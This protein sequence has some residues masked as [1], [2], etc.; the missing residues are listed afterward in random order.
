[1][2][3]VQLVSNSAT[4]QQIQDLIGRS[5]ASEMDEP[6][7]VLNYT[8]VRIKVRSRQLQEIAKMSG[9]VWM[10]PWSEPVL[11]DE[12]QGLILAGKL[13]GTESPSSYL[14]WLQSKG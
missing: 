12:K 7:T 1:M 10:E 8:N 6:R 5:S 4:A 11:H 2:S 13:T 9:V 14:A 3:I